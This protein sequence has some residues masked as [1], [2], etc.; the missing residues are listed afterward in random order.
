[1]A[2]R[3]KS[4]DLHLVT[5]TYRRDRHGPGGPP[6][7]PVQDNGILPPKRLK[8]RQQELWDKHIRILPGL[9]VVD[10]AKCHLWVELQAEFERAPERMP[11]TRLTQL[12]LLGKDL[13]MGSS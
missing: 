13:G 12:R 1:M 11:A 9:H 5:G 10:A 2:R 8:K 6:R 7:Q 4:T 3:R